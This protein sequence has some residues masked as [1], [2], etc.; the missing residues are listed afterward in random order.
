M[1]R[2]DH[3]AADQGQSEYEQMVHDLGGDANVHQSRGR[4][5]KVNAKLKMTPKKLVPGARKEAAF[6]DPTDRPQP[7]ATTGPTLDDLRVATHLPAPTPPPSP[8]KNTKGSKMSIVCSEGQREG[9]EH[10]TVPLGKK[11][12]SASDDEEEEERDDTDS[13]M[14]GDQRKVEKGNEQDEHGEDEEEKYVPRVVAKPKSEPL[15]RTRKSSVSVARIQQLAKR[16]Q[17]NFQKA[18]REAREISDPIPAGQFHIEQI[19]CDV[20]A[21]GFCLVKWFG[22]GR[23][24]WE[25]WDNMGGKLA[26][27]YKQQGAI[28]LAEYSAWLKY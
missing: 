2:A 1:T 5:A 9:G 27:L 15:S 20:P 3:R 12:Q 23:P 6:T 28:T 7:S 26:E 24:S 19:L 25:P 16:Y 17:R 13:K 14:K 8:M 11:E 10:K 18:Q 22:Y 4:R 21:E